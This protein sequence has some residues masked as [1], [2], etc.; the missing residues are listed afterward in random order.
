MDASYQA[1][2]NVITN[3]EF[4]SVLA[5]IQSLPPIERLQATYT[6][7]TAQALAARGIP[8]PAQFSITT[9]TSEKSTSSTATA[10]N[11][12]APERSAAIRPSL[13]ADTIVCVGIP[14]FRICW[15]TGVVPGPANPGS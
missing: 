1:L 8:I 4:Q 14:P 10:E 7:L 5:E 6:Q 12:A 3:P 11:I 2:K 9:Y 13:Q 15:H